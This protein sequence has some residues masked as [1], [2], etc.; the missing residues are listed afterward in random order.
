MKTTKAPNLCLEMDVEKIDPVQLAISIAGIKKE[1]EEENT[2]FIARI[3]MEKFSDNREGATMEYEDWEEDDL[4]NF[5]SGRNCINFC[6]ADVSNNY[7]FFTVDSSSS[8]EDMDKGEN[9][10]EKVTARGNSRP[11]PNVPHDTAESCHMLTAEPTTY[12]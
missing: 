3:K 9:E 10:I 11:G 8:R 5:S 2:I 12:I 1:E 4:R 7:Q 6:G